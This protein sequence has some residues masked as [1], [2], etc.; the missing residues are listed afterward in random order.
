MPWFRRKKE[1]E[2][3]DDNLTSLFEGYRDAGQSEKLVTIT[4]TMREWWQLNRAIAGFVEL[5]LKPMIR[6][7]FK[8]ASDSIKKRASELYEQ[9]KVP[10]HKMVLANQQAEVEFL[11]EKIGDKLIDALQKAGINASSAML[12]DLKGIKIAINGM[13]EEEKKK[14]TH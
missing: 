4:M 8:G 13:M 9:L 10:L 3:D 5:D 14:E 2:A 6:G 7:E 12:G 1:E 11:S